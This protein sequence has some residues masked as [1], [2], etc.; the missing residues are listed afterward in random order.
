[1]RAKTREFAKERLVVRLTSALGMETD[2]FMGKVDFITHQA[3]QP[4]LSNGEDASAQIDLATLIAPTQKDHGT[5][6]GSTQIE[7][8]ASPKSAAGRRVAARHDPPGAP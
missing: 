2:L 1:M 6:Q 3:M 5:G 8:K 7:G 4:M